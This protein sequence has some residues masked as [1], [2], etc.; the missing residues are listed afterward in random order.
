[1]FKSTRTSITNVQLLFIFLYT[2]R[3]YAYSVQVR[4]HPRRGCTH[5]LVLVRTPQN[6]VLVNSGG[7]QQCHSMKHDESKIQAE[8]VKYLQSEKIWFCS[9]PNEAAGKDAAIRMSQL[10]TLGLRSGAPDLLVF[11]P[12]RLVCLEVKSQTGTQS[13]AQ[14]HFQGKL[15]EL[16]FEYYVV[17]SVDDVKKALGRN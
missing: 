14:I 10:K 17:R 7:G 16:N 6:F 4:T 13:P 1:M 12:N 8:I 3:V 11:L 2:P 5:I 15:E 9:C